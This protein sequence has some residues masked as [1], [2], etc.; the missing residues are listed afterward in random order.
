MGDESSA[1]I[2][3]TGFDPRSA[4]AGLGG[5][6]QQ[7]RYVPHEGPV[8]A[9]YPL[10]LDERIALRAGAIGDV[11][12]IRTPVD[13]VY[14]LARWWS[15]AEPERELA[16]VRRYLHMPPTVKFFGGGRPLWKIGD[17]PDHE[18]DYPV[19]TRRP[20]D[21]FEPETV[22]LP[23]DVE[24]AAHALDA[25]EMALSLAWIRATSRLA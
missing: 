20:V 25:A 12:L 24:A 21:A 15:I 1:G 13:A 22:G 11:V 6:L 5:V 9:G 7:R 23:A 10:A 8:P 19:P 4:L 3:V 16:A 17:D 18:V 14:R 2:L